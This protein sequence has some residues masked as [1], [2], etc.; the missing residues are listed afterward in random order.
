VIGERMAIPM[1]GNIRLTDS[2][3]SRFLPNGPI[4]TDAGRQREVPL[5]I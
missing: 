3:D 5:A 1:G 2:M 4:A